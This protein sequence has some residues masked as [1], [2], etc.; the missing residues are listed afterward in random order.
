MKQSR[1]QIQNIKKSIT[2]MSFIHDKNNSI[3]GKKV[4][5]SFAKH[6]YFSNLFYQTSILVFLMTFLT[7]HRKSKILLI[8]SLF[9]WFFSF[10]LIYWSIAPYTPLCNLYRRHK[11][12]L[13]WTN[14]ENFYFYE[15]KLLY[16]RKSW[17]VKKGLWKTH[18]FR[19]SYGYIKRW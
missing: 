8:I 10:I 12:L 9:K 13:K 16:P 18:L 3:L 17:Y 14:S 6:E 7:W 15:N 5:K 19:A 1:I 11:K 2:S 4:I